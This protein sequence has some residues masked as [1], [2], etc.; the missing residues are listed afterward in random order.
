MKKLNK[1][2]LILII[3]ILYSFIQFFEWFKYSTLISNFINKKNVIT[4]NEIK[5]NNLVN[6]L[7]KKNKIS[8]EKYEKRFGDII[9]Y[10]PNKNEELGYITDYSDQRDVGLEY[11]L[12][13]YSLSPYIIKLSSDKKYLIG[14]FSKEIIEDN[15]IENNRYIFCEE[16]ERKRN[17]DEIINYTKTNNK[18][19]NTW[20]K[21]KIV[22]Y[23]PFLKRSGNK[24]KHYNCIKNK[25]FKIVKKF[26]NGIMIIER[27]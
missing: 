27:D 14:N 10:L 6:V 22:I 15:I 13:Q 4:K 3:L 12:T 2:Y 19:K 1:C 9:E 26:D 25:K 16:K 17:F 5:K 21:N 8:I 23:S 20:P 18:I 24:L 7:K 11:M